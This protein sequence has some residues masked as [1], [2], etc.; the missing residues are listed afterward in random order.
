MWKIKWLL[1]ECIKI[2]GKFYG[3]CMDV[4]IKTP[5]FSR[6]PLPPKA[7]DMGVPPPLVTLS[8]LLRFSLLPY[9]F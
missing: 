3:F 1:H 5:M 6:L 7:S 9:H 4:T 2:C 8:L